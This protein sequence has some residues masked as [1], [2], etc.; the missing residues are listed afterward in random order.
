MSDI[1]LFRGDSIPPDL[2]GD[3]W[4]ALVTHFCGTGLIARFAS[5]GTRYSGAPKHSLAWMVAAHIGWEANEEARTFSAHSPFISFSSDPDRA[6]SFMS[7]DAD[8]DLVPSE[9]HDA[10]FFMWAL[11]FGRTELRPMPEH[12]KGCYG[13]HYRSD[14]TNCRLAIA[15]EYQEGV[16]RYLSDGDIS[17][18]IQA[19][20]RGAAADQ[21]DVAGDAHVAILI[22]AVTYLADRTPQFEDR[23]LLHLAMTCATRDREWLVFPCDPMDSWVSSTF[24]MNRHLSIHKCF[25][26]RAATAAR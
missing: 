9:F 13:L 22:D 18:M 1:V 10:S 17:L 5:A 19:I 23:E 15:E 20:G 12:G 7:H 24:H 11:E 8:L 3:R 14:P 6:F 4:N 2:R 26:L 21:N 25:T 16:R